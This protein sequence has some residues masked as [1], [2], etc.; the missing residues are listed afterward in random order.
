MAVVAA[1]ALVVGVAFTIHC[2]TACIDEKEADWKTLFEKCYN[3]MW[4]VGDAVWLVSLLLPLVMFALFS[5][6]MRRSRAELKAFAGAR[7]V[8]YDGLGV[9]PRTSRAIAW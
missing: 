7:L 4:I 1:A 5:N 3:L 2:E 8:C 9:P 6:M